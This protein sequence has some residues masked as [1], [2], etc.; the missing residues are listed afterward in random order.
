[1]S[2]FS[3]FLSSLKITNGKRNRPALLLALAKTVLE[4][5]Y[6]TDVIYPT[7]E[8]LISNYDILW[9]MIGES[10]DSKYHY[11]FFALGK[12]NF[13]KLI[14][15]PGFEEYLS[16][17][18]SLRSFKDLINSVQAV[19]I[20]R[21]LFNLLKDPITNRQFVDEVYASYIHSISI[22][23][24]LFD[25]ILEERNVLA[26]DDLLKP[27]DEFETK[28]VLKESEATLIYLRNADFKRLIPKLY[29]YRC[30]ITKQGM[31]YGNSISVEACHI[32]PFSKRH[33][34]TLYNGISLL[35]EF[36]KL[37]DQHYLTIDEHYHVVMSSQ[38]N[39]VSEKPYYKQFHGQKLALPNDQRCWPKPEL[40]AD[41]RKKFIS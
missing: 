41:H 40:L 2:K 33:L 18:D 31:K 16:K 37:F 39:D 5:S 30:A 35:P 14:P 6:V 4:G 11:P 38:I 26:Y 25:S 17:T 23:P 12:S 10:G 27:I 9:K 28:M 3:S 34:C 20:D 15:N 7:D 19:E 32:E 36:H 13:W 8:E 24:N 29:D 22:Q 21:A 1:M